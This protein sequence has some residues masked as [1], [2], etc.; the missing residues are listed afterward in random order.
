MKCDAQKPR[1]SNCT[2]HA[3][4]CAFGAV[5]RKARAKH[6][7][8]GE[9]VGELRLQ[10]ER[11]ESSLDR[12]S[13]RID[14]LQRLVPRWDK[15]PDNLV[16]SAHAVNVHVDQFDLV[17]KERSAA[18]MEL[19]PLQEVLCATETYLGTLNAFLP[20]FHPGR[21]RQLIHKWYAYPGQRERTT[22]AAINVVLAL[23]HRQISPNEATLSDSTA[24]YLHNAQTVLSEVIMGGADL[25]NVQIFIGM[26]L[27]FQGTQDLKPA[28]MLIAVA[29]RLAH[30]LGLH[31]RRPEFLEPSQVLERDRVFWIAYLL[32]RDISMRTSQPPIQRE[33]DI[34][35]GWP[36]AEPEDGAG[37][38]SDADGT[39]LFNFLRCRVRLA[40]IQG[41]VYDFLVTGRAG[42]MD[43]Y[44]RNQGMIN[45]I[46]SLDDWI[47]S[48]PSSFRPSSMLHAGQPDLCRNFTVLYST[49][50]ACRTQIY[51]AHAMVSPWMQSLRNFGRTVTQAGHIV[52]LPLPTPSLS[53]WQKLVEQIRGY[54]RLF[55]GVERRDAAFIWSE[56]HLYL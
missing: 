13:K 29:L 33:A 45:L 41:N 16:A 25:L 39:I 54:M 49:H 12:A 56:N 4:T 1:C 26:V 43:T 36:S 15:A 55:C 20:L 31:T 48:I 42:T 32:D 11:L 46:H 3:S 21:L 47:S 19:P 28:M 50:L 51:Q 52:P 38:V 17:Q 18:R 44:H 24:S 10:I 9:D 53:D 35:I 27:L 14:E 7:A 22:W 40:Q 23:A 37:N 2:L 5:S 6:P 30:E 34:D 8:P